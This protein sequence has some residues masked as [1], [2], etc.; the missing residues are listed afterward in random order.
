MNQSRITAALLAIVGVSLAAADWP[1]FRGADNRSVAT[2]RDLPASWQTATSAQ[3]A[4]NI[5]WSVALPG[6]G[7]SSPIVVRGRAIVTC[8]SGA[9]QDRLHVLAI[10]TTSG[11]L[12]WE[13]QCWATGRTLCHP[14]SAIA[15][16]T[17]SS[18]GERVFAFYSSNDLLC[19]DLEGNLQW[20]RGLTLESPTSFNDTGMSSSPLVIGD[21]VIIQIETQGDSFAAGID[22]KTGKTRWQIARKPEP[23]WVS[24]AVLG[25]ADGEKIL[26]LQSP[27]G[28]SAH[29]PKTGKQLAAAD[30]PCEAIPSAVGIDD[31]IYLPSKGLSA[32]RYSPGTQALDE[33]WSDAKLGPATASPI[34]DGQRLYVI[35]R[36]GALTCAN[37]ANGEVLWR[38][39][40]KGGFWAT[41]VLTGGRLY[42]FNQEGVGQVVD[43]EHKGEIIG[44]SAMGEMV[45]ASPA[46]VDDS[47]YVRT[48]S[49]LFKIQDSPA[50]R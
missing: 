45:Y 37:V 15:A 46:V 25:R 42:C 50:A 1:Q 43:I 26:L 8:S 19:F 28:I 16:P 10:D 34:I 22:T 48:S 4:K 44:T 32:L 13:R 24:P 5:A 35:N 23:N 33:L 2:S 6:R 7:L 31:T 38:T 9:K 39:R 11:K 12:L 14:T 29:D 41:P 20:L 36:A 27:G 17:P 40:L 18:D 49:H 21:V 47:L 30:R 3:P